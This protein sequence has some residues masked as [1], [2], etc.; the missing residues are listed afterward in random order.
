MG[1]LYSAAPDG[2]GRDP[3]REYPRC[4]VLRKMAEQQWEVFANRMETKVTAKVK[5]PLLLPPPESKEV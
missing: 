5:E 1:I 4:E 2:F 3:Q